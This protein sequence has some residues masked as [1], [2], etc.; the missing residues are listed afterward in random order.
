MNTQTE[1][2]LTRPIKVDTVRK[3]LAGGMWHHVRPGTFAVGPYMFM[4][5]DIPIGPIG[6]DISFQF[7]DADTDEL[8]V[9][10]VTSDIVMVCERETDDGER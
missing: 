9:G 8:M 10:P 6:T 7:I 2:K 3:V 4:T 5:N 1:T